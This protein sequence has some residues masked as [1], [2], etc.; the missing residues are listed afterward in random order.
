LRDG[1]Q[2]TRSQ[3]DHQSLALGMMTAVH[4]QQ[5]NPPSQPRQLSSS[6]STSW[7]GRVS[8]RS[9]GRLVHASPVQPQASKALRTWSPTNNPHRGYRGGQVSP[10]KSRGLYTKHNHSNPPSHYIS[11]HI[12]GRVPTPQTLSIRGHN[13][14]TNTD[15]N[16]NTNARTQQRPLSIS[17]SGFL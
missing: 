13:T 7:R 11:H 4:F 1:G 14:N 10:D 3:A 6:S 2:H 17:G 8:P 12:A 5:E 9:P 15:T 16:T